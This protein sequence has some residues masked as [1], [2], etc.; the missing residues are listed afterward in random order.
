MISEIV[1][2]TLTEKQ[3]TLRSMASAIGVSHPTIINW[4]EGR[5]EPQTDF[6]IRCRGEHDDWRRDFATACLHARM[7]DVF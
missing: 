5:S 6:L 3:L 2:K 4:R 1:R 7:P